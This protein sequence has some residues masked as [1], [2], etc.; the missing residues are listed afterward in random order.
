MDSNSLPMAPDLDVFPRFVR[1][2][3]LG[4]ILFAVS[5]FF[6]VVLAGILST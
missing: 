2:L 4:V 6:L 3:I 1:L 5:A